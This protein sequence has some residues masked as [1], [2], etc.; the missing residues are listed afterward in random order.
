V[1]IASTHEATRTHAR[2][3]VSNNQKEVK[4]QKREVREAEKRHAT[5]ETV[6]GEISYALEVQ[7][8]ARVEDK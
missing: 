8:T 7:E 3:G 4:N 5:H 1:A 6:S 2:R